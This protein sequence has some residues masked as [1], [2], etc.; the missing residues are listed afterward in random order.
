[1]RILGI[2]PARYASS[3]FPGKPLVEIDGK[4]MIRR[5][6]EQSQKAKSLTDVIVATDDVKI[7]QEII[8]FGGK[9]M[10]TSTK[11][12]SG[13][14]RCR[15]VIDNLEASGEHYDAVV[16][17]QGDEPFIESQQIDLITECFQ[18]RQTEIATLAKK[19]QKSSE[20]F[21]PNVNKVI[22]NI[23]GEAI[24]FS[25][26]PIPFMQNIAKDEWINKG[27]YYKHIGIY[28][29]RTE[30]LKKIT[31]LEPGRLE[32]AESLEQ[33]RWIEN[34]F[35]IVVRETPFDSISIDTPEDLSEFL[36][37]A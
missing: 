29:Y 9:V 17:I 24:Y 18:D 19:I 3:R 4:T 15:E 10:I 20:L 31:R 33:L 22:W 23:R 8:G 21:S 25:R 37:N 1:M 5:V 11:H 13:T 32:I 35:K 27:V 26:N 30:T 2:I 14:D 28:G 12:R 36:N 16:N 6:Y 34:G 7:E